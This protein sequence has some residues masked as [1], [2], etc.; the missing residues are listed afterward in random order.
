MKFRREYLCKVVCRRGLGEPVGNY[1]YC[2]VRIS[3]FPKL[4]PLY[5]LSLKI[6]I[7]NLKTYNNFKLFIKFGEINLVDVDGI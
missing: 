1:N 4:R 7:R 5:T 2:T 3:L 6:V